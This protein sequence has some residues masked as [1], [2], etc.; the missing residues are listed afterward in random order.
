RFNILQAHYRS[1][2]DFSDKSLKASETAFQRLSD[3]WH[4][5]QALDPSA[6]PG[7]V[8]NAT[9]TQN[10][11]SFDQEAH[12]LM[13]DDLNTARTIAR[14]FDTLAVINEASSNKHLPFPVDQETFERF[15]NSFN[16][17][18]M[19][20][21]GLKPLAQAEASGDGL[22]DS[23]MQFIIQLRQQSRKDK[24]FAMADQIRDTLSELNIK[25]KDTPSGTEWYAEN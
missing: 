5:L 2:S 11:A 10:L 24:N 15:R 1:V 23:L 4:R 17:F 20:V 21:L 19:E 22:T 9:H 3:A 14:M 6:F 16:T 8:A 12:A 13:N 25:L 18:F 7:I